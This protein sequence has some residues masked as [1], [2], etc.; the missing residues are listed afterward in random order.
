MARRPSRRSPT[1]ATPRSRRTTSTVC[2]T[3]CTP[4]RRLSRPSGERRRAGPSTRSSSRRSPPVRAGARR[5][6]PPNPGG[7]RLR[8]RG[9]RRTAGGSV[10]YVDPAPVCFPGEVAHPARTGRTRTAPSRNGPREARGS[11]DWRSSTGPRP[12]AT[13]CRPAGRR[14]RSRGAGSRRTSPRGRSCRPRRPPRRRRHGLLL[15]ARSGTR[16][17][18]S[19]SGSGGL[20][21]LGAAGRPPG[22][23]VGEEVD[24]DGEVGHA[25]HGGGAGT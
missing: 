14:A 18:V 5:G 2:S 3:L 7:L 1:S 23:V 17:R 11:R 15:R 24:R 25:V 19:A 20:E 13:G 21:R 16:R 22:L 12:T 6:A 4:C 10:A 9:P 8:Q